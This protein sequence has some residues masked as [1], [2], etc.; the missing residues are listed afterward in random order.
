MPVRSQGTLLRTASRMFPPSCALLV[1]NPGISLRIVG[2]RGSRVGPS[3]VEVAEGDVADR[4]VEVVEGRVRLHPDSFR[5]SSM[6]RPKRQSLV[7]GGLV[8][9][10]S[11][12]RMLRHPILL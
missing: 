9:M 1:V 4:V 7:R 12:A 3:R 2:Q 6:R 11:P 10:L 8:C 5:L